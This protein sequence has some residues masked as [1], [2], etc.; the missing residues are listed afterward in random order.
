[1]STVSVHS[2]SRAHTSVFVSDKLRNF[3]KILV[4]QYGLDPQGVVDAWSDW[5]D[6]AVRTWLESGHLKTIV[7][8]FYRPGSDTAEAR[9]DFPIRYDGNGVDEM[10]VDRLFFEESFAKAK[11]PTPGS[12]YRIVLINAPGRP[13][14]PG[15]EWTTLRSVNGLV[16]REA[17]TV[18]ATPDIMAAARYYRS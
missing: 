2:Y 11:A 5:V 10:W 12:T 8:E 7:I 14:V 13:D 1:M 17:G 15:I 9:W 6:H 4:R 3:L 16:A 18:I